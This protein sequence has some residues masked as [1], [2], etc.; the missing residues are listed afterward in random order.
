MKLG[1][2]GGGRIRKELREESTMIKIYCINQWE[3][4]HEFEEDGGG[5]SGRLW[6]EEREGST[7]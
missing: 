6:R 4:R 2:K 3:K 5:T 7:L 1:G